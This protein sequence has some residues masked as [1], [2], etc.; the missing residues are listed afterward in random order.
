[1]ALLE[2]PRSCGLSL[3]AAWSRLSAGL[4]PLSALGLEASGLGSGSDFVE[5]DLHVAL[6]T[7]RQHGLQS[8]AME[9]FMEVLQVD[10]QKNIAAEFWDFLTQRENMVTEQ[11]RSKL[12]YD[13]FCML[14]QRLAP[15]LC[16][17]K[18]LETWIEAGLI[19]SV[20]PG[21]LRDK[22]Y[23]MVKAVLFFSTVQPF[24]EIIH[25]FYT[26]AFSIYVHQDKT[27]RNGDSMSEEEDENAVDDI[28]LLNCAGC[29]A[30]KE[31]CWCTTAVEQFAKVNHVL[32]SLNLLERISA[33]AITTILHK[34]IEEHVGRLCRGEYENSFLTQL[35]EVYA[36]MRIEEL[37]SIIRDF[38]ES[39]AALQ[40]LKVCLERTN[41]RQQLLSS[42]KAALETR[43]LHPGVNTADVITLYISA[44]KALR[45][46]DPSMVILEVVCEPVRKYLRTRD[47]TVRQIVAGLT[48][49]SEGSSD[50]ANELSK[51]D[52]ITLEHGHDSDD[53]MSDP[54]DWVP[55][56][57]DADPGKFGSKRRSSDIIT[58]LVS[59]YGS[60]EL[61]INEYRTLLADRIL[62]HF[63]YVTCREIRNLELLKLRFGE[64]QMHFCEVM[65]K[66]VADSRRINSH[67]HEEDQ[68][69]PLHLNAM[70]LSGEFWPPLKEE[71]LEL[72]I[73]VK[74]AMDAYTK[75]YEKLKAMRSLN[76]KP[77]LG[78]V[79]LEIEL[80]DRTLSVSVSPVH[81]AIIMHFQQKSTWTLDELSDALKVPVIALRRKIALWQQQ[82][83]LKEDPTD[84]FTVIEEEQKDQ[85]E[86]MVLIDSDEEG[87]SAMASQADQKEEELQLF[88]TYIQ[89]MLTNL[90]SLPLERIHT[91]LKM[92]VMTGPVMA[93]IDM[94]ELQAFLQKKVKDHQLVYSGGV[95]RLPKSNC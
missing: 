30:V 75:K 27:L 2:T 64:A 1:M 91:M 58:L 7:L 41:Q 19:T 6:E 56:P 13:A 35:E 72:P 69:T 12:L 14:D 15:Y 95:Y 76:W 82:G 18:Y 37:F 54:D 17:L 59:I 80:A 53:D 84:T 36:N 11:Q 83:V 86:K 42:L 61:F 90:E 92:F 93:E 79:D 87:D 85:Q 49:D 78:N 88:W 23:T 22:V 51:A 33:S 60:K 66:D 32:H 62:H 81:A 70:I 39:K 29:N 4:V 71:K 26:R 40:D 44:I 10:L 74:E 73:E 52:P 65:L 45:E 31:Q 3:S 46:L 63:S 25:E 38:P 89:G 20:G 57:V 67:I 21:T 16:S 24:Q 94:Q 43:L 9:W 48:D 50:L 28:E 5:D 34:M 8:V 77:H 68:E 47:D 55:D